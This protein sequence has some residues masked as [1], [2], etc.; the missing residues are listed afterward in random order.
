M[1][2]INETFKKILA[3]IQSVYNVLKERASLLL[4]RYTGHKSSE[5][6]EEADDDQLRQPARL[7]VPKMKKAKPIRRRGRQKVY[8]LKGYTTVAKVNRK[9]QAERQQR[10]LRRALLFV[11]VIIAIILMYNYI[12]PFKNIAEWYRF[13]GISSLAEI[14]TGKTT[15]G[16]T[17]DLSSETTESASS[18]V[19]SE[20]TL[21]TT[22]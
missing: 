16:T 5:L 17:I 15:T 7:A 11:I 19:S 1:S 10:L 12:N 18:T 9:R 13:I 3:R 21:A 22:N 2:N 8:R 14:I 4:N 6:A 20:E